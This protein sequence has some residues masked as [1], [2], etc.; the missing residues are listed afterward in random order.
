MVCRAHLG[1]L[2]WTRRPD[3]TVS[4]EIRPIT[5]QRWLPRI[6]TPVTRHGAI[7]R[8]IW[9]RAATGIRS[10]MAGLG[11]R[12]IH[13]ACADRVPGAREHGRDG[14]SLSMLSRG[15]RRD[16]SA[17]SANNFDTSLTDSLYTCLDSSLLQNALACTMS[18]QLLIGDPHH[19][20]LENP[21]AVNGPRPS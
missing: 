8:H 17:A 16:G 6:H 2:L 1:P 7:V 10:S 15:C 4:L 19:V 14:A 13:I 5:S 18:W 20:G 9:R 21:F 3:W 12:Y 11:R